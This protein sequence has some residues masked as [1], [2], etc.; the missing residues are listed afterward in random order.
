MLPTPQ[1]PV[2]DVRPALH[3]QRMR[4]RS[5]LIGVVAAVFAAWA[6]WSFRSFV[7]IDDCLD[8]GGAWQERGSYCYGVSVRGQGR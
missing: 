1:S 4:K 7:A 6:G 8:A 3:S 2:A 5:I